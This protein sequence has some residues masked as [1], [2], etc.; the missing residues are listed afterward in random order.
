MNIVY[1]ILGMSVEQ[2][3]QNAYLQIL[4][5]ALFMMKILSEF[6]LKTI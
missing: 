6:L 5:R 2:S 4:F 1:I 3:R